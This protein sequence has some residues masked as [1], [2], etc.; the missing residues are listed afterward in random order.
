MNIYPRETREFMAVEVARDGVVQ[1]DPTKIGFSVVP[2]GDRPDVF[3]APV[4]L[5]EQTG[6]MVDGFK[7]GMWRVWAKVTDISEVPVIDCG[8]FRVE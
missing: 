1:T 2:D 4:V 8:L 7:P 6:I 5:D 3:S